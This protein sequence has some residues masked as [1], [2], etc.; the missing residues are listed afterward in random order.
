MTVK[1]L[2]IAVL[3]HMCESI[4]E[5]EVDSLGYLKYMTGELVQNALPE[6]SPAERELL[7]S[8][9]CEKCFDEICE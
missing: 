8:S 3:C 6:L 9:T 4:H 2:D 7:I 1:K 5:F